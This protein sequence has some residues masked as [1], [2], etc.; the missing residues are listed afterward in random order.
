MPNNVMMNS[1]LTYEVLL[2]HNAIDSEL[3]TLWM[4]PYW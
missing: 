4:F 3:S 2:I 1:S